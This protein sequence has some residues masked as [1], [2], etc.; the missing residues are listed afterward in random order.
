MEA[1]ASRFGLLR[2]E[3]ARAAAEQ[4][5]R[6]A[7]EHPQDRELA[8]RARV[9]QEAASAAEE[10]NA[11][12]SEAGLKGEIKVAPAEPE[13]IYQPRKDGVRC[14]AYKPSVLVERSASGGEV[15]AV[16][17]Q[18]IVGQGVHPSSEPALFHTLLAQHLK[19][20]GCDPTTV[21][22]DAGYA[23]LKIFAD[24][25]ERNL[26][27]LC[28]SGRA[29]GAADWAKRGSQGRFGK[30]AFAYDPQHDVYRCPAGGE[31][32]PEQR[33]NTDRAGRSYR[34]YWGVAC[35]D[36]ALRT[37]CTNSQSARML[38]RYTNEEFKEGMLEVM[39]QPR[40]R[41]R[42]R[43]R[44]AIVE[45]VFAEIR[46]RQGLKRFHRRGLFAVRAEFALHCIAFNLKQTT[47]GLRL[48]L[49]F[50]FYARLNGPPALQYR[51]FVVLIAQPDRPSY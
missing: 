26:D 51:Q 22:A 27:L 33:L 18:L 21:L 6:R 11:R 14:A 36:C 2:A 32:L 15:G 8:A 7:A 40:A 23:S 20:F 9:A 10:R 29:R 17:I 19:S 31:L 45:R 5:E 1:A 37:Q 30:P 3:A 4:A 49:I 34:R 35:S 50:G 44:G 48:T 47:A 16:K 25:C 28:P 24:C 43:A 41:A 42:Y 39:L 46:E 12:R 38:K 13:A